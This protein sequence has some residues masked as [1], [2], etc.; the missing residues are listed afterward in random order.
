MDARG[1]TLAFL[2]VLTFTPM[3]MLMRMCLR[4]CAPAIVRFDDRYP[5]ANLIGPVGDGR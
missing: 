4:D 3:L 1:Y 2:F 5:V